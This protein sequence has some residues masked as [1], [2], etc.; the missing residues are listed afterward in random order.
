LEVSRRRP[1]RWANVRDGRRLETFTL[2]VIYSITS[3]VQIPGD[4][5]H[6]SDLKPP[7]VPE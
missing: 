5:A 3:L 1:R 7:N 2:A 4:L 6:H